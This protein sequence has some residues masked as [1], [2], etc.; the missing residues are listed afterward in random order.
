[1]WGVGGAFV[2]VVGGV[3]VLFLDFF[4]LVLVLDAKFWCSSSVRSMISWISC[5]FNIKGS[6]ALCPKDELFLLSFS[7]LFCFEVMAFCLFSFPRSR[8]I[9]Y[10]FFCPSRAKDRSSPIRLNISDI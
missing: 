3:V 5:E 9:N 7:G 1:M 8:G 10:V 2:F 6:G 4:F